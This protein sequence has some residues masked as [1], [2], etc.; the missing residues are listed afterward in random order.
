M[1]ICF[2]ALTELLL[3]SVTSIHLS[4]STLGSNPKGGVEYVHVR[5]LASW[6]AEGSARVPGGTWNAYRKYT[7]GLLQPI[8]AR[9]IV[10]KTLLLVRV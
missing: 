4:L 2:P 3:K 6:L 5:N 10:D 1:S 7:R 8:I 9:Q